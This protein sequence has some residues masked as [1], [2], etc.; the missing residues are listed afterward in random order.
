MSTN[1]SPG[2]PI[3]RPLLGSLILGGSAL[4]VLAL[5][6]LYLHARSR[7]NHVALSETPRPVTVVQAEAGSYKDQK[8]YVGMLAPW[9]SARVGPQYVSAY[10]STVLVR[11]GDVVKQGQVLATLDCRFSSAESRVI[12][13][14]ARSVEQRQVA[15]QHES[16]RMQELIQGGFASPNEVE[17]LHAR[18]E[19]EAAELESQRA[20]LV[21]KGLEVD[22]C[23][24][25][26]PFSGDVAMRLVD[27][28]AYLHPGE[29]AV[30]LVDR[31]TLRIVVY[32]PEA[33][34][35]YLAPGTSMGVEVTATSQ[36]LTAQI[37]RR[38]P[39][40]DSST[41]TIEFEIDVPN[42]DHAL[43]SDTTAVLTLSAGQ[44]R[45]AVLVPAPAAT[46][47]GSKATLFSV[48]N[49]RAR[50]LFVTVLGER[51]GMLYLDPGKLSSGAEVV[52]EGRAL[53]Q[54]GDAVTT[55]P[56]TE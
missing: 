23:I 21:T 9:V 48:E 25:R 3:S 8:T 52:I 49:G 43:P 7:Q 46:T 22:D 31:S 32:A 6:G 20:S 54:E 4:V 18:S 41:R 19:S 27:P 45:P 50:R 36:K 42:T 53:L 17:Q 12:A 38:S 51:N 37:S 33:D 11:P 15:M 26:A 30:T 47:S 35:P 13:S 55:R 1:S 29:A 14:R 5:I 16:E 28:G 39:S 40:A 2:H 56:A 24:L 10:V 44:P 34:W